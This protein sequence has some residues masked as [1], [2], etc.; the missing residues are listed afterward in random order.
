MG[1]VRIGTASWTDKTL[2]ESGWYPPEANN[3]EE[4]LKFYSSQ[5]RVVEVDSTYYALP[6]ERNAVLWVERTPKDFLFDVKAFSMMTGHPT[7]HRALPK[8]LRE[9][10]A[11]DAPDPLYPDKVPDEIRDRAWELFREALMPL[12]SAGKLGLVMFQ[13]PQWFFPGRR[14]KDEIL[15]IRDRLPDY[16]FAVEF[17]QKKWYEDEESARKTLDFLRNE[18]IPLVCVDMPQGF[19]SS[20]PPLAEATSDRWA[21]V[22]FHGRR[23][24]TWNKRGVPPI[25]RFRYDYA[26]EEL[27]EWVPRVQGL[28][29]DAK[30]THALFN[31]CYRDYATR[32]AS[33]FADML[34]AGAEVEE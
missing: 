4:R 33:T 17:R 21:V 31:N 30:E 9:T 27:E 12:H 5:F 3:P 22:R 13:Y 25:E 34:G 2:L 1:R 26:K 14:A 16:D 10:L 11:R 32:N 15:A 8:D 18:E 28:Q 7:R 24:E 6:T 20:L 19:A 23:E 29:E